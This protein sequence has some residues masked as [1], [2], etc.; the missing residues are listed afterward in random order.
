[1]VYTKTNTSYRPL[2]DFTYPPFTAYGQLRY[3]NDAIDVMLRFVLG[4]FLYLYVDLGT[5]LFSLRFIASRRFE[6]WRAGSVRVFGGASTAV[7]TFESDPRRR[8]RAD[9]LWRCTSRSP[10]PW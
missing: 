7:A 2:Q 10:I 3:F 6:I 4:S 8:F 9:A 1:M 5:V